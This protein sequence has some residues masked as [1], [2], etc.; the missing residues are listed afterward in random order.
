[1]LIISWLCQDYAKK[2]LAVKKYLFRAIFPVYL[3]SYTQLSFFYKRAKWAG[4]I[5][6][7]TA[8]LS[9]PIPAFIDSWEE[10]FISLPSSFLI[11][12]P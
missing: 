3:Q 7:S 1:M 12:T 5:Y 8:P 9:S 10:T 11:I 2:R 4:M 6:L